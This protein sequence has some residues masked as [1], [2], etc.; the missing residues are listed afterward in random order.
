MYHRSWD[1][2][3]VLTTCASARNLPDADAAEVAAVLLARGGFEPAEWKRT[4]EIAELR[5]KPKLIAVLKST[6]VA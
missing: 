6:P 3:T 2:S 4:M 5:D 1:D